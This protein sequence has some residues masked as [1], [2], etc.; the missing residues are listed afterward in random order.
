MT[1]GLIFHHKHKAI[2]EYTTKIHCQNQPSLG[3]LLLLT[4]FSKPS[5]ELY[6]RS[7]ALMELWPTW[8]WLYVAIQFRGVEQRPVLYSF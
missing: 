2:H 8:V 4:A 5:G 1:A 3:G 7:G 6:K